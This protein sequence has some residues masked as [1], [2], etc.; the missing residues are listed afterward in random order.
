MVNVTAPFAVLRRIPAGL[1][2]IVCVSQAWFAPGED[3]V[4]LQ[5]FMRFWPAGEHASQPSDTLSRPVDRSGRRRQRRSRSRRRRP[6]AQGWGLQQAHI[7][8]LLIY[9]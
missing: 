9:H 1:G 2:P 5:E 6:A 4:L 3:A 7:K 8:R